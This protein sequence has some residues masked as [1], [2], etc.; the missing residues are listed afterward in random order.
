[1]KNLKVSSV[2]FNHKTGEKEINFAV[3][4]KYVIE[5]SNNDVDII[6]FP[7]MCITGYWEIRS[8]SRE[9]V[10]MIAEKVPTGDSCKKLLEYSKKYNI[11]IG[12]GMIEISEDGK[13]YNSYFVAMPDG[14]YANHRKI[15]CFINNDMDSGTDVTVFDTP[16]GYMFLLLQIQQ[17]III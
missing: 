3:M 5:A 2:Q 12:A 17:F 7:E 13:L 11:T 10:K 6:A 8:Y 4:E 1:M 14:T 15:H 9:E 16:Y